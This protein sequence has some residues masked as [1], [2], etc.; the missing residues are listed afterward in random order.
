MSGSAATDRTPAAPR[1]GCCAGSAAP[2]APSCAAGSW[3]SPRAGH[4]PKRKTSK[5]TPCTVAK[6]LKCLV[7]C[8]LQNILAKSNYIFDNGK[9]RGN[10]MPQP[11]SEPD[12]AAVRA[13]NRF[14][15]RKLGVL[16]QLL[17]KSPFSLREARVLYD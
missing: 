14:Y 9:Y 11:D 13:F 3:S 15:T 5:T 8:K 6:A 4:R 12:V 2:R 1:R 16:D 17:L 7:K 10:T